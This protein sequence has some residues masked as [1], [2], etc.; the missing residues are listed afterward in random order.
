[1]RKLALTEAKARKGG[2]AVALGTD[3]RFSASDTIDFV[4]ESEFYY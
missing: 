4:H 3:G 2:R 1:M